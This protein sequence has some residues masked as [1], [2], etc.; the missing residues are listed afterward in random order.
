MV[1]NDVVDLRDPEAAPRPSSDRFDARVFC[2]EELDALAASA[3]RTRLRWRLWAAK[4]AAYK[5]CVKLDP[6]VVF[7]PSRFR[8]RLPEDAGGGSVETPNGGLPLLVQERDGWLHAVATA[9]LPGEIVFDVERFPAGGGMDDPSASVRCFARRV[10]ARGLGVAP[11]AL[12][13]R[14][15]GRVP[16]LCRSGAPA[17]GDLSLSHHGGVV[18]F[19]YEPSPRRVVPVRCGQALASGSP[20]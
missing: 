8:V 11:E 1:G 4:E 20:G 5:V 14:K 6:T 9:A 3:C 2:E 12:E 16:V 10:L 17:P 19:A 13:I 15:R 18:A 7:S